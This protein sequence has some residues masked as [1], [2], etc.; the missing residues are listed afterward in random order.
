MIQADN[1][2]IRALP[3]REPNFKKISRQQYE[4]WLRH[5]TWDALKGMRYGQSFCNHFQ[6]WDNILYHYRSATIADQYIKDQYLD[7]RR[8]NS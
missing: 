3:W 8:Y 7:D 1:H 4:Y 2:W 5:Y 6:I